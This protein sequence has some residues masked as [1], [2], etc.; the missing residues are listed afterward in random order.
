MSTKRIIFNIPEA[1]KDAAVRRAKEED[2][3][4]TRILTQT[5]LLYGEGSFDPDDFLSQEDID[6]I[7]RAKADV[8][9][10]RTHTL[11]EVRRNVG[12]V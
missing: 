3:T 9:E 7:A 11:E 8:R 2:T 10:G 4:L 1:V 6:A 12:L 5:L